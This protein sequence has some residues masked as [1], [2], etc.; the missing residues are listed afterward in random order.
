MCG[1]DFKAGRCLWTLDGVW[2]G[3]IFASTAWAGSST[4]SLS[5]TSTCSLTLLQPVLVPWTHRLLSSHG[6]E[7]YP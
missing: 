7:H 1:A 6:D 5:N 3:G 4:D 2:A